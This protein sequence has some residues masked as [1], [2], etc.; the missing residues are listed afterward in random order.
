MKNG[1]V[2]KQTTHNPT[3]GAKLS[4]VNKL[5][6]LALMLPLSACLS[7]SSSGEANINGERVVGNIL[8]NGMV[9]T[10]TLDFSGR[11]RCEG[12]YRGS[13]SIEAKQVSLTCTNGKAGT[14]TVDATQI[15]NTASIKYNIDGFRRGSI[16]IPLGGQVSNDD[17]S[18]AEKK[19]SKPVVEVRK[20]SHLAAT[21]TK[22]TSA[23][24]SSARREVKQQMKDPDSIKFGEY[25]ALKLFDDETKKSVIAICGKYNAKN[26][27]GGYTGDKLFLAKQREDGGWSIVVGGMGL[28]MC[29]NA[30][31]AVTNGGNFL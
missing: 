12:Q 2:F 7:I 24:L 28:A 16:V 10:I 21:S 30:G 27:Y 14:A 22:V 3:N 19:P 4:L 5:F 25:R 31:F 18:L 6:V 15:K 11:E 1:S 23:T 20:P 8:S 13:A 26:S 17:T 29:S 9:R